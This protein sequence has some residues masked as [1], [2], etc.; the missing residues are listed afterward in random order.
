V[1]AA[2]ILCCGSSVCL[3]IGPAAS[4]VSASEID[5]SKQPSRIVLGWTGDPARTMSVTWRTASAAARALGQIAP[6]GPG[7]DLARAAKTVA[8]TSEALAVGSGKTAGQHRLTFDQLTPDTRYAYRVG[9]G[10]VWSPWSVF[11]TASASPA[12]FSFLYV[13]DAQNDIYSL[14]SRV[15]RAAYAA[16]PDARFTVH[17]GDL[18]AEGYDD[19]L[20]GEWHDALGFIE[21]SIPVVPVPGNHDL[22][23]EPG[24]ALGVLSVSPIWRAQF[25]VPGNGPALEALRQQCYYLDYQGVRIVTLD[26]NAFAN[27]DFEA[28][29]R[30]EVRAALLAWLREVLQS[31]PNRWTIVV[32][33]QNVYSIAGGRD[34]VDLR[35]ALVPLFDRYG[36]DLV[37]QGHDHAYGRTYKLRAGVPV[38]DGQ[39]GTIYVT[40]VS[41]PKMYELT[42]EKTRSLMTKLATNVQT[43][44]VITVDGNQLSFRAFTAD[45]RL[46]DGFDLAKPSN[47]AQPS[48]R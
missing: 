28:G 41:G 3:S 26:V 8:G 33:H 23:R 31:N 6:A 4:R 40:S 37:L 15:I 36:V 30:E 29:R 35:S 5:G 38:A 39:A 20:W 7:P 47:D 2:F 13:G 43:Y 46:L 1:I 22:H 32:Q 24:S 21:A 14:W 10:Q 42:V 48:S 19:R 44:Q 9:D 12:P 34:Y 25:S 16:A 18:V 11:R 27:E 45:G 17:A